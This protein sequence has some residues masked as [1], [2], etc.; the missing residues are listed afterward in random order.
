MNRSR[1]LFA[2][3]A[4]AYYLILGSVV[5][6][7][8]LGLVMVLSAS[9]V[10]SLRESGNSFSFVLRQALFLIL[11]AGLAWVAMKLRY[12]LWKPIA[13]VSLILSCALLVLPQIGGIGKTVGG[14]TNWIGI[15]SFTLQPSEFAK[16]GLILWCALRLRI[17]DEKAS[18]GIASNPATLVVP[19]FMLV[20]AL[21]LLGR[22]LGTAVL[23]TGIVAGI[24]FIS[25]LAFRVFGLLAGGAGLLF[26]AFIL[27]NANRMNRFSAFFD[28]FAEQNYQG[29]GWQQA[30][31]IMG[32]ASGG[33]VG[34]GLGSSKQKW[35]SL[36]E[37]HTDFIFAVIG[38]ELGLLG[39]LA[40]LGLFAI[41]ILGIFKVAINAQNSFDRYICAGIG[42]WISLQVLLNIGTVISLIPVVGVTLP[43]ISYGGSS[44][45][46]TF[47][48]LGYVLGVLRRD[49]Q[50]ASEIRQ[51]KAARTAR[52]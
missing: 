46:A 36:P 38:E 34:T 12:E 48:A 10:K 43:L 50:I 35:G 41:L 25:G 52:G 42:C 7:S 1:P 2:T 16:L 49:P 30:H 33:A 31:S 23:V 21:I 37:V 51:R 6:L 29:V 47:I 17:H 5:A 44:L 3:P 13:Q 8:S 20:M 22:D 19:G 40:T 18:Q 27:P 9:S 39:T 45:L 14:N 26:A 4:S 32:L 11:A 15:G 24:L 28:P